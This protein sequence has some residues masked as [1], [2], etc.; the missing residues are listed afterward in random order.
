METNK[1]KQ[2]KQL[3]QE[4][5][6]GNKS[7]IEE[8]MTL[9]YKDLL[10]L[11]YSYLKDKMLAEDVVSETFIKLIEKI[12]TIKNEQN[13]SGYLRTIVINKSLNLIR[14]RKKE[15]YV[16]DKVL[17]REISI[18]GLSEEDE[19]VRYILSVLNEAERVILLLWSY[20]YTLSEIVKR[21][22]Y[23]INQVRLILDKGKKNFFEKYH[24][25]IGG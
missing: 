6:A 21:T 7:A 10:W 2:I 5:K 4:F 13:L 17:D 11:S 20:G 16:E 18:S 23:T 1:S 24:K 3:L 8:L 25:L 9:T 15:V 14:N 22:G 19:D 12:H